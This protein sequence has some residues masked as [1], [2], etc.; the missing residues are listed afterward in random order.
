[1]PYFITECMYTLADLKQPTWT[2]KS[3]K[4]GK[5]P[6]EHTT[7]GELNETLGH[8]WPRVRPNTYLLL[9]Y[10]RR[11]RGPIWR[12]KNIAKKLFPF[13][14]SHYP[15]PL[16]FPC[17]KGDTKQRSWRIVEEDPRIRFAEWWSVSTFVS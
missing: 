7:L 12:R 17:A 8:A 13:V 15:N 5:L 2:D 10:K 16:A 4:K 11:A 1:M 6:M 14:Y 9:S 3:M